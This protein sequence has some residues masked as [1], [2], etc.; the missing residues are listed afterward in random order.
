[1]RTLI[2][3]H[4]LC[5]F[6]LAGSAMLALAASSPVDAQQGGAL[7]GTASLEPGD[8][9]ER[10]V[11]GLERFLAG[12]T[13]VASVER[14]ARWQ[15]DLSSSAAYAQSVQPNRD[16]L[17]RLI[18]AVDARDP[19]PELQIVG[20]PGRESW[21]AKADRYRVYEVRWRA[22]G[23]V[24]GEGLLLEP[25]RRPVAQV[26]AIP[27]CAASPEALAG[28]TGGVHKEAQFARRLA[29]SGCRVI[30][31][32]LINRE[33]TYSGNPAIRMTNQPHREFIYR[34]AFEMGRHILGYEVLKLEALMDAGRRE[35]PGLPLGIYGYGEGGLLALLTSALDQRP[36]VTVVS[37]Q[38]GPREELWTE[39]IYRNLFGL[40]REFGDAEI[41]TLVA[42]RRLLVEPAV[43]PDVKGP[44]A[45]RDGRSG[46]APGALTTITAEAARGELE[47]ATRMLRALP[48]TS[49]LECLGGG[50]LPGR[51]DSLRRFLG[52]LAPKAELRKSGNPGQWVRPGGDPERRMADQ[53]RQL[54]DHNQ[55]LL[56]EASPRRREY[57][58]AADAGSVE[59]WA[60]SSRAYRDRFWD[61][62]IGRLPATYLPANPRA[63]Q[64]YDEPNYRGYEVVLDV[65]PEVVA[66]GILLLPKNLRPG[67]RRPVVVCQHGL[68]GRPTDLANP[69]LDHPAYHRYA[70]RLADEGF[71][72]FAPQN[73]Y[74]FG[75][76]FRLLQRRLN[77]LGLSLFSVITAQHEQIL[78]WLASL[79]S[80]DPE[81]IAFYGLSYGGKT[82]MRVPAM[83]ERYC[84]SIC[85]ADFNEWIWKNASAHDRYSYLFTGEWEMVEFNLG[86]TFNY[87]EMAWLICPRPFMVERGH[88]DGVAPSEQV[89]YE[90]TRVRERYDRLGI[91]GRTE[92]EFFNGP[93]TIHGVG[94]F[95]FL[96]RHLRWPPP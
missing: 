49:T 25:D 59:K 26:I 91:G 35:W 94:T 90:F 60:Q 10:M 43:A 41:A 30:V 4:S 5:W 24:T 34:A 31:P 74:I 15:R 76:R 82:A 44:P 89:G 21:V 54:V 92:I 20:R 55:T 79:P 46:A 33:D 58:A 64:I 40:L 19:G 18:G 45:P 87:A 42:P 70:C 69:A 29:E 48:G 56:R 65:Y 28:L 78:N 63:R 83:L 27:D 75:D 88:D 68:E 96:R 17:R 47:R 73:P 37:G 39:P 57:W 7:P 72:V 84:L 32:T 61:D 23:Q 38:F 16:R 77:P 53:V 50:Q 22:F 36:A 81:R 2:S 52:L 12:R 8:L 85:S 13:T 62:V 6:L 93:H 86:N 1:M 95:A 11:A 67:E 14:G 66:G 3:I 71:I 9:A 80:V 51:E